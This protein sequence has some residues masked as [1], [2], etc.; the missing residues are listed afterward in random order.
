MSDQLSKERVSNMDTRFTGVISPVVTPFKD[1]EVDF[2]S[3]DKVV[4]FLIDGGM[5]GLFVGGSSG[6][7]AYLTDAQRDAVAA[8]VIER[9]AGR[10][11][12]LVGAI[13]TTTARVIEQ[14]KRAAALGA[15]AHSLNCREDQNRHYCKKYGSYEGPVD[16]Q[17]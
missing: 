10:V 8:R 12:V 6:E 11:P 16:A 2:E 15:D 7:V 14:A 13:D 9:T 5:N 4:D 17:R 1:G 3:L